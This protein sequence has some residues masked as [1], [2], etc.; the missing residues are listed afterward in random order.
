VAAERMS[1]QFAQTTEG[2]ERVDWYLCKKPVK[3][4]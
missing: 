2:L 4:G 1:E 3:A